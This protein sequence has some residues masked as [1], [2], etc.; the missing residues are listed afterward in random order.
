MADKGGRRRRS[1]SIL[2]VYHE[3]LEPVEQLSDQAALPNLNANWV[4]AKGNDPLPS[5]LQEACRDP[6]PV[7]QPRGATKQALKAP[8]LP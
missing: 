8:S 4:N 2:Q 7:N 5:P 1:S 6:C 3:P